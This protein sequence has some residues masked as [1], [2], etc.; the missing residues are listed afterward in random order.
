MHDQLQSPELQ[1][2]FGCTL[3]I[4]ILRVAWLHIF[5]PRSIHACISFSRASKLQSDEK[6]SWV[7]VRCSHGNLGVLDCEDNA[8]RL[9]L[10]LSLWTLHV[11]EIANTKDRS[12]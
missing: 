4:S 7:D 6:Y 1:H 2:R 9:V 8:N 5:F 12:Y 10:Q 3:A 11:N